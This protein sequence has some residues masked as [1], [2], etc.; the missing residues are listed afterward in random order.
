MDV[1]MYI[2]ETTSGAST[3]WVGLGFASP[4]TN[5]VATYLDTDQFTLYMHRLASSHI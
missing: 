1:L 2:V 4:I 5:K 3:G